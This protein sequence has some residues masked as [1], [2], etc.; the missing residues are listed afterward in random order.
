MLIPKYRMYLLGEASRFYN[1]L[2]V[3]IRGYN[4]NVQSLFDKTVR[5]TGCPVK[6]GYKCKCK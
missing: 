1:Y 2:R 4:Y 3:G 6:V 5:D